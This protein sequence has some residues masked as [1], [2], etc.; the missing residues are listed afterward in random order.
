MSRPHSS[1]PK[2]IFYSYS[3]KDEELLEG[4]QEQLAGLKRRE[5]IIGWH[6]RK[7]S[8]G[9]EWK[10]EID[11]HLESSS[12]ILLLVSPSFLAS[13]YCNDVEVTK[14]IELHNAGEARVI[15]VILR[16]CQWRKSP[17]GKLQALP[18]DGLPVIKWKHLDDAFMSIAEGIE[19]AVEELMDTPA[20]VSTRSDSQKAEHGSNG[21]ANRA[22]VPSK[23]F[24]NLLTPLTRFIGRGSEVS[25]IKDYLQQK[26]VRIIVVH[27][28]GGAGKSRLAQQAAATLAEEF[29]DGICLVLLDRISNPDLVLTTIAQTLGLREVEGIPVDERLKQY[30]G[31]KHLLLL[32]DNFEHV[33]AAA[34]HIT[35]LLVACPQLKMLL[36]SRRALN[37]GGVVN[38]RVPPLKLPP[39]RDYHD[40]EALSSQYDAVKLFID[41]AKVI[42]R[43]FMVTDDNAPAVAEIC[44]RLDGLPLAIELAAARI[45]LFSPDEMLK[46]MAH[47]LNFFVRGRVAWSKRHE[48][49]RATIAWSYDLLD[50]PGEKTLLKRISVFKDGCSMDA[51]KQ[52]CN[53]HGNL[54]IELSEG[55]QSLLENNLLRRDEAGG[56]RHRFRMP[57]MIREYG[58][59]RLIED[60]DEEAQTRRQHA[61]YFLALA[62]KSETKITSAERGN[63]LELLED[64]HA[65]FQAALVWCQTTTGDADVGLRLAGA[66]FWFWNLRAHFSDGRT[67][68]EGALLKN[69][70]PKNTPALAK[71]L[72]GAGGLAFLQGDYSAARQRLEESVAIWRGLKEERRL[73]YALV[74]LG[75][76]ALSTDDFDTALSSELESVRIFREIKDKWGYALSLNDLG[77]VYR[78]KSEYAEAHKHYNQSLELWKEMKETWGLPLTLSNL[79]FLDL[80]SGKYAT[81]RRSL[82]KALR[83]QRKVDDKQGRAATLKYLGDLAVRQGTKR[84]DPARRNS[85]YLEAAKY[86]SESLM[87]NREIEHKQFMVAA[88]AGL[89]IVVGKIGQVEQA[90]Q[91]FG[92]TDLLRQS[93][94]VPAKDVDQEMYELT[95]EDVRAQFNN[96]RLFQKARAKGQRM[97]LDYAITYALDIS[98]K[99]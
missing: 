97:N 83:I 13:D 49:M 54:G 7:I 5:V 86:Y 29:R 44:V 37:I 59:E 35:D 27:G 41:R 34:N 63:W 76:V 88:L 47:Q 84:L 38:Y 79:G 6:D 64:E 71:A 9:K 87:L 58:L 75:M 91:L 31:D 53:A 68:L 46:E 57:D 24:N 72:Y 40:A 80:L 18:K 30:L 45:D 11:K 85:A 20:K 10:G 81:A 14:A 77:N 82:K 23:F 19:A 22:E 33:V 48:T 70:P 98:S 66:L 93:F 36:T 4:L 89:T 78:L 2:E 39:K 28:I 56:G 52:V 61:Q 65:N 94:G 21:K 51:A 62:E 96:E 16:P 8:A 73:A 74:I 92:A 1:E 25:D 12:V 17:L 32:L 99:E 95:L 60:K 26:D 42:D 3:H 15:P 67:W 69:R 50:K 90:A 55:L 43:D